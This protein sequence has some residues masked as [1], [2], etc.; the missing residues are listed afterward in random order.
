MLSLLA[1]TSGKAVKTS[2]SSSLTRSEKLEYIPY[3]SIKFEDDW[4]K[5]RREICKMVS[6]LIR[7]AC[8]DQMIGASPDQVKRIY[9][10]Y[11]H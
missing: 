1:L 2:R 8:C 5:L 10:R 11:S 7:F 9:S 6:L 4:K 3:I